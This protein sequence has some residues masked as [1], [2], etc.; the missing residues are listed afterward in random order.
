MGTDDLVKLAAFYGV[1]PAALMMAPEDAGPK[2]DRMIKASGIAE[3]LDDDKAEQ[4]LGLG[5]TLAGDPPK[6]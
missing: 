3:R 4:W 5:A 6:R 2:I 1:H